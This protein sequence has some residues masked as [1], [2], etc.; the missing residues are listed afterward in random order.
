MSTGKFAMQPSLSATTRE[1]FLFGS[2]STSVGVIISVVS[3]ERGKLKRLRCTI[4]ESDIEL[5]VDTGA[6]AS[7]TN[8]KAVKT[9]RL[10]PLIH[11][12]LV[13]YILH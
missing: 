3:Y 13:D 12:S 7:I 5:L 11:N 10:T 4:G 9:I 6:V 8:T 2:D 1:S